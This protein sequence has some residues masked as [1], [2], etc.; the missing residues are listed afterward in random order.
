MN[1][2]TS[3][4]GVLRAIPGWV[5]KAQ[6]TSRRLGVSLRFYYTDGFVSDW[7]RRWFL[8]LQVRRCLEP[9][10][11]PV[12]PQVSS[13]LENKLSIA[14]SGP[15]SVVIDRSKRYFM[16]GKW[17]ITGDGSTGQPYTS[18]KPIDDSEA[19]RSS[20]GLNVSDLVLTSLTM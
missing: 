3:G 11:L 15:D 4:H 8:D 5:W 20:Y 14:D 18:F 13:G 12:G 1:L 19:R 10:P 6:Q 9:R 17:K 2:D 16:A 7:C